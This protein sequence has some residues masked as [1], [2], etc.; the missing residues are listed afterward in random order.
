V[1]RAALRC[2]RNARHVS[3]RRACMRAP[4][5]RVRPRSRKP[6]DGIARRHHLRL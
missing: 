1:S 2:A 4:D 6:A 5:G 3:N